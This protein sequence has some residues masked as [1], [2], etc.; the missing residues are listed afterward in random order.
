MLD[1]QIQFLVLNCVVHQPKSDSFQVSHVNTRAQSVSK[2]ETLPFFSQTI[3]WTGHIRKR[4]P[5]SERDLEEW[6]DLVFALLCCVNKSTI[7]KCSKGPPWLT[8]MLS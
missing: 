7:L 4:V 6:D 8:P 1:D 3:C 5:A 2:V